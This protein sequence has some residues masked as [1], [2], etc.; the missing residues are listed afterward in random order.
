MIS[1]PINSSK[2]ITYKVISL[3]PAEN[4]VRK[5]QVALPVAE[6]QIMLSLT[7]V[8]VGAVAV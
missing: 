5:V 3:D 2:G 8:V 1:Y 6:R 4:L 7:D